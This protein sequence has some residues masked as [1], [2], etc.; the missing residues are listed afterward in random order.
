MRSVSPVALADPAAPAPPGTAARIIGFGAVGLEL[1]RSRRDG[2]GMPL[3]V[4][5]RGGGSLRS[6]PL[7]LVDAARCSQELSRGS[8]GAGREYLAGTMLCGV[9]PDRAAPYRSSCLG[10]SGGPLV[11]GAGADAVQIGVTSWT[12]RCGQLAEPSIEARVDVWR[13]AIL[14]PRGPVWAPRVSGRPV[15]RGR[16]VPGAT[17]RCDGSRVRI[18][19]RPFRRRYIFL[20]RGRPVRSR[21]PTY[22]VRTADRGSRLRCRI[23]ASNEGGED[24]TAPSR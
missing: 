3:I 17:V 8:A 21:T 7:E 13:D 6:A 14:S 1:D 9:D 23:E 12:L 4:G 24:Q 10:D 15:L 2:D 11:I 19:G 16:I 22:R 18:L 5:T 20:A